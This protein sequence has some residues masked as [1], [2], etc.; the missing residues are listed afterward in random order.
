MQRSRGALTRHFQRFRRASKTSP[1]RWRE[2]RRPMSAPRHSRTCPSPHW[3][4][5]PVWRATE[6]PSTW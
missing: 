3:R 2:W 5:H 1:R 4:V 6:A